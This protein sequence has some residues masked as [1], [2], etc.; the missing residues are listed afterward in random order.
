[1]SAKGKDFV[2]DILTARHKRPQ[3]DQVPADQQEPVA[4]KSPV[5]KA[6]HSKIRKVENSDIR[7]SEDSNIHKFENDNV[8]TF[9]NSNSKPKKRGNK[10]KWAR[11]IVTI[12][13]KQY[14]KIKRHCLEN[15]MTF[16]SFV[17]GLITRYFEEKGR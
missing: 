14:K 11:A 8:R 12:E 2:D 6:E 16:Q 5:R 17:E 1:M 10:E 9:E 13:P 7:K 3:P 15:D 4:E